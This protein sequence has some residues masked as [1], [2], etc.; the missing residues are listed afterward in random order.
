[1][2]FGIISDSH[3]RV[4][5]IERAVEIF[6]S[7]N[8]DAVLHCG[9]FVSP[10]S[11]T[12][13]TAL[14]PPMYAVYGNNDGEKAGIMKMFNDNNWDLSDRPRSC[15]IGDVS[16]AMLH[17]P[18]NLRSFTDDGGYD[19][20]VFGHTHQTFLEK[21]NDAMVV[22]PGEACGWVKGNATVAIVDLEESAC[23]FRAL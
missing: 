4:P 5:M 3:D 10:F 13:L 15:S 11:L 6:N 18:D 17:E 20:V 9:D 1:V 12:P 2:R 19:L 16:I 21:R 14:E 8:L 23:H 7:E 22:N